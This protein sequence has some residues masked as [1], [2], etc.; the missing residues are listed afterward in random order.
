MRFKTSVSKIKENDIIIRGENL[1]G[2]VE[3]SSFSDSIFLILRNRKPSKKESRVFN[4][5]LVSCIDHG[6]G[7]LSA[8]TTRFAMSG[9]HQLNTAVAAGLCSIGKF[10]GGAI[11]NCMQQLTSVKD[12]KQFV[13]DSLSAKK[14]IFGFGHKVYKK[15]DPRAQQILKI[16]KEEGFSSEYIDAALDMEKEIEKQKGKKLVLNI[17]GLIAAILLE[18]GFAPEEGNGIFII[19]RLPGLIAHANEERLKEKPVR[20][21]EEDE[22]EYEG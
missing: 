2:L 19:A 1:S 3:G 15:E 4:A 10:H 22:I 18:M 14:V 16:C 8:L 20:R 12:V 11:E 21:L 6:M 5:I 7:T 9:T 17:D 13:S